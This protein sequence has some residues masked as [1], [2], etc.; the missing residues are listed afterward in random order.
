LKLIGSLFC[1]FLLQTA[2]S[3]QVQK[4]IKRLPDT[5]QTQSF[6]TTFGED[7]DYSIHVPGFLDHG[8]GTVTDTITGL[9]WQNRM[10]AKEALRPQG[11]M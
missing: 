7:N 10:E 5:G 9:M 11:L 2:F 4:T 6:T 8:N 3:Q 1:F